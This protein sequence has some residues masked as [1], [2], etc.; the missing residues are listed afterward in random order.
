MQL[1]SPKARCK[2]I[3]NFDTSDSKKLMIVAH[4]D[5]ETFWGGYELLTKGYFVVCVT[6]GYKPKRKADFMKVLEISGNKGVIL[7]F[8]DT[9]NVATF[10]TQEQKIKSTLQKII[11]SKNWEKILTHCPFGEY[12][13][14]H[15]KL[16][17]RYVTELAP[18]RVSYFNYRSRFYFW[19]HKSGITKQQKNDKKKLIAVYKKSQLIATWWF[20]YSLNIV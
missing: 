8:K 18:G 20:R 19:F 5:D 17:S 13:H 15:H 1:H 3:N 7:D 11:C 4:P 6:N 14:A 2:M 10:K 9:L 16:I 12:G